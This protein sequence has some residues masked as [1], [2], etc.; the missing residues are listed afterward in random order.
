MIFIRWVLCNFHSFPLF[1]FSSFLLITY[2]NNKFNRRLK[3]SGNECSYAYLIPTYI[4]DFFSFIV[5][6][7]QTSKSFEIKINARDF[8][9]FPNADRHFFLVYSHLH[10]GEIFQNS[11]AQGYNFTILL[12]TS[13][14]R[15]CFFFSLFF[16]SS[17]ND[18]CTKKSVVFLFLIL[19]PKC[20]F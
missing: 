2:R 11:C 12:T 8:F 14:S 17:I 13:N 5:S 1:F 9:F 4:I 18:I 10:I 16:F 3:I 20:T 7:I 15:R 19:S 6:L